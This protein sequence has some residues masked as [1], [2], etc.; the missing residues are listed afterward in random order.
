MRYGQID[1]TDIVQ[2]PV[3]LKNGSILAFRP[4]FT[5]LTTSELREIAVVLEGKIGYIK[6]RVSYSEPEVTICTVKDCW[7]IIETLSNNEMS[8]CDEHRTRR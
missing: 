6:L 8:R 2:V 7:K 5:T 4:E 1:V 3:I